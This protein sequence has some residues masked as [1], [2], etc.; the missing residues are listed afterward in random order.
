VA[1]Y[2]IKEGDVRKRKLSFA[3]VCGLI[4]LATS[5]CLALGKDQPI[6][7]YTSQGR[8]IVT[9]NAPHY[10]LWHE[11]ELWHLRW[12]STE[13]KAKF[14]GT[15]KAIDGT[16]SL[17]ERINLEK[18]DKTKEY[19]DTI[20]FKG[21]VK[22]GIE[23]FDF[24]WSGSKLKADLYVKGE[25][26]PLKIY[27]GRRAIRPHYVPFFLS[28]ST[29]TKGRIYSSMALGMPQVTQEKPH[30]LLWHERDL[31]HLRW[32]SPEKKAKFSGVLKAIDGSIELVRR[33]NL[34]KKDKTRVHPPNTVSFK[35]KVKEQPEGFD[36]RWTGSKL[37]VDLK[38]KGEYLPER[39]Y[40]GRKPVVPPKVPF[41][42][43]A[44]LPPVEGRH[45]RP[46][47]HELPPPFRR[48]LH[49]P[50]PR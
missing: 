4:L 31:W 27:I 50:P 41:K 38:I 19:D 10:L 36:F 34:E 43:I 28:G 16:I 49:P 47:P 6:P 33:V 25:H 44:G 32:Q 3:T 11:G 22:K 8:P 9:D 13:K 5:S 18:K 15:L 23:G 14:K 29:S 24:R 37:L 12:Q 46:V 17:V 30:Y 48:I 35:G 20:S 45:I 1:P 7:Y 26:R 39:I 21:R 40:I 42:I 2:F